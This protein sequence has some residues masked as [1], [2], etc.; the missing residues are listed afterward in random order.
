MVAY[1]NGCSSPQP[2]DLWILRF[3]LFQSEL[4]ELLLQALFMEQT[5][6]SG[7]YHGKTAGDNI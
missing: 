6:R 5:K 7:C 2:V 3:D 1:T 4:I